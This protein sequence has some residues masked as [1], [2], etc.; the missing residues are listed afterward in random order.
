MTFSHLPHFNSSR[1]KRV[2]A[3]CPACG[4]GDWPEKCGVTDRYGF[5]W[6]LAECVR[7]GLQ[8]QLWPLTDDARQWFYRSGEYRR[9]CEQVTGKPWTDVEFLHAAQIDYARKWAGRFT[10]LPWG[11]WLDYGGSTGIVSHMAA[12]AR[13]GPGSAQ[14]VVADYGDGATV[15][16]EEAIQMGKE[17]PYDAIICAQTLDHIKDPLQTLKTFLSVT[18]EG[19]SL[20]C[21]V[22]KDAPKKVDHDTYWKSA[23]CFVG[24][25]ERAGWSISWL[26]SDTHSSH[27]TIGAVKKSR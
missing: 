12:M 18:R 16:P 8:W 10:Q 3:I 5:E 17:T 19:G 14:V 26:D 9:L 22:V 20:F 25:V 23:A 15:T 27:Y 11:T 7:C 2:S 6:R 4:H 21:D 1:E 24:V 13:P